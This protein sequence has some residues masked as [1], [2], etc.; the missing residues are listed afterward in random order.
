[1]ENFVL[2]TRIFEMEGDFKS[3]KIRID[4]ENER[5]MVFSE[6]GKPGE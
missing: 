3:L 2:A 5:E 6:K 4:S 1:M